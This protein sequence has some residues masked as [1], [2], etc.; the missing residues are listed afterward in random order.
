M[1]TPIMLSVPLGLW[2][3][4]GLVVVVIGVLVL[5]ALYSK[6]DVRAVFSYGSTIFTLEAKGRESKR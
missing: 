4:L 3:F 1:I 6:G 2:I 5:Y